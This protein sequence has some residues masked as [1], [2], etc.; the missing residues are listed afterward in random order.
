M[1][2]ISVLYKVYHITSKLCLCAQLDK[3]VEEMEWK[4]R[5]E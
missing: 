3:V 1:F 4:E 2:K 5:Q